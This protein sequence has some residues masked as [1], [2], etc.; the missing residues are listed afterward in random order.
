MTDDLNEIRRTLEILAEETYG[1]R[2]VAAGGG[3]YDDENLHEYLENVDAAV[4][5][6]YDAVS[7]AYGR[8]A[9]LKAAALQE[10][11]EAQTK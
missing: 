3:I 11:Q 8:A 2:G 10:E 1:L 7:V 9:E 6:L 5:E 4:G